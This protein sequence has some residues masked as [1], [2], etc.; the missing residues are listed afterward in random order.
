MKSARIW[1]RGERK[2]RR[3]GLLLQGALRISLSYT[4]FMVEQSFRTCR[5]LEQVSAAEETSAD[6]SIHVY[7]SIAS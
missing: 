5:L 6:N 3:V 2:Q 1:L 7:S 4:Y